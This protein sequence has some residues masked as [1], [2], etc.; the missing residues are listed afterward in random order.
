MKTLI[1]ENNWLI[2]MGMIE[3][4]WGNGYVLI[5]KNH[6]LHGAHYDAIN[7][8]VDVHRGLT[9]SELV[10]MEM[11]ERWG[12]DKEDIGKWCVGFDTVGGGANLTNWPEER[13]L[14]EAEYLRDQLI[15][16]KS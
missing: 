12:A 10:D 11:V 8:I 5:P 4:G 15:A 14:K 7:E 9:F 13:V 2:G 6:P 3:S 16:Y 1:H